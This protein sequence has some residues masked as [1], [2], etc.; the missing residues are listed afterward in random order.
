MARVTVSF[1]LELRELSLHLN[2]IREQ[3]ALSARS[4]EI[5][6]SRETRDRMVE[7]RKMAT[8]NPCSSTPSLNHEIHKR[9]GS[10]PS[11]EREYVRGQKAHHKLHTANHQDRRYARHSHG[12][13]PLARE[14]SLQVILV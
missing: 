14:L 8:G 13:N 10:E 9:C 5:S 11:R 6:R 7:Q 2:S 3:R 1:L 12:R 4:A